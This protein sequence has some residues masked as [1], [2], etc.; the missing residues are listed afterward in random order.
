MNVDKL[1]EVTTLDLYVKYHVQEFEK[2][3]A[4]RFPCLLCSCKKDIDRGVTILDVKGVSLRNFTKPVREVILQLQKIDYDYYPVISDEHEDEPGEEAECLEKTV[5]T[6]DV[7][8]QPVGE[9]Q[10]EI[11]Y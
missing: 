8:R 2:S 4:F 9:K 6:S 7:T 11:V 3:I 1:L 5:A 10:P